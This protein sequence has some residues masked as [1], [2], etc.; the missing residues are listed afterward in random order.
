MAESLELMRSKKKTRVSFVGASEVTEDWADYSLFPAGYDAC[1]GSYRAYVTKFF[2]EH[3]VA[4]AINYKIRPD[5]I[6]IYFGGNDIAYRLT[7]NMPP[8]NSQVIHALVQTAKEI[9]LSNIMVVMVPIMARTDTNYT[10]TRMS[11]EE[12]DIRREE[13]NRQVKTC[14]TNLLGYNPMI[15]DKVRPL[16]DG[17]HLTKEGYKALFKD[18]AEKIEE[19]RPIV[20]ERRESRNDELRAMV[21]KGERERIRRDEI[22][23][24]QTIYANKEKARKEEEEARKMENMCFMERRDSKRKTY[25][26]RLAEEEREEEQKRKEETRQRREQEEQE[27]EKQRRQWREKEGV[28][29][30]WRVA[31]SRMEEVRYFQGGQR[32]QNRNWRSRIDRSRTAYVE[33]N[34]R[35]NPSNPTNPF[36]QQSGEK[37]K[38]QDKE[39]T[40]ETREVYEVTTTREAATQTES[41]QVLMARL[42][43]ELYQLHLSQGG[44]AN[45]Q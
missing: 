11:V 28:N 35:T 3:T 45:S 30:E 22:A 21:L 44:N 9:N 29:Q 17:V 39:T 20:K 36:N 24:R 27:E 38:Q 41:I 32:D 4:F 6:V 33:K 12:Y 25:M 23:R 26:D 13:V 1:K 14:T 34:H 31:T 18:I 40:R 16:A 42:L 5:V 19:I 15:V 7:N 43:E 2:E 37:P 8:T 10:F